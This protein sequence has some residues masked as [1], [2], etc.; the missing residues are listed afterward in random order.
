MTQNEV[1]ILKNAVLDATEAY[2]DARLK[3]LDFVKTQIGV[4]VGNPTEKGG[5]YYHTVRCNA[6][7]SLPDGITYKNV[8]S[9]GNIEFP[10]NSVVFLAAPNAQFSNQFILGK[11]DNTPCNIV[12]GSINIGNGKFVV[13]KNGNVI[14][15]NINAQGGHIAGFTIDNTNNALTVE[16]TKVSPTVIGCGRAGY[17]I[18]NLHAGTS[19][20]DT[21]LQISTTGNPTD[22]RDG[23]RIFYDGK[24]QRIA[25]D[26]TTIVWTKNFSAIP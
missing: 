9:V 14:C 24:V 4:T 20:S 21:Y 17:G 1:N 3:V 18:I 11:L 26:G 8:L 25:E 5:K 10:A 15:K 23:I 7:E 12:G 16:D 13:D 22:C 6:T 2:V 19:A